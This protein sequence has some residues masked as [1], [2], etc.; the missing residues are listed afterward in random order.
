MH[1]SSKREENEIIPR[2]CSRIENVRMSKRG[3]VYV[4]VIPLPLRE[5]ERERECVCGCERECEVRRR[6]SVCVG[7]A[8][9]QW[10]GCEFIMDVR[11]GARG[12]RHTKARR[13]KEQ[14]YFLCLA[15]AGRGGI[16]TP[17][18]RYVQG[19]DLNKTVTRNLQ[20]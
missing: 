18:V 16:Y 5:G 4:V 11:R 6:D 20:I 15:K 3:A 19:S 13:E 7:P 12:S 9:L 8:W 2:P 14:L 10:H 1:V 17:Q